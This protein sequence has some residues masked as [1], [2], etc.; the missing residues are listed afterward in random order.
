MVMAKRRTECPEM[1][2][3]FYGQI[4]VHRDGRW[5]RMILQPPALPALL[6]GAIILE[7]VDEVHIRGPIT[8][9]LQV[10]EAISQGVLKVRGIGHISGLTNDIT[11]WLRK[12]HPEVV[13]D[14]WVNHWLP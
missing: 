2:T 11:D 1:K 12:S 7:S 4:F 13:L 6:R 8:E 3:P 14:Y 9:E 10:R 5:L